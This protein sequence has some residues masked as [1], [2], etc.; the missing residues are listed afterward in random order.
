MTS[1]A[2]NHIILI[3][4]FCL[5][6]L[7]ALT[8]PQVAAAT[9]VTLVPYGSSDI[10]YMTYSLDHASVSAEFPGI[11]QP[12]FD[13]SGWPVGT[14]PFGGG[15]LFWDFRGGF[16]GA[17]A[18]T[19]WGS[20]DLTIV[21]RIYIDLPPGYDNVTISMI[22]ASAAYLMV[23]GRGWGSSEGCFECPRACGGSM[24]PYSSWFHAGRNLVVVMGQSHD[25]NWVHYLDVQVTADIP[26]IDVRDDSWGAI[27]SLF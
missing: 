1:R 3:H 11:F 8:G 9:T 2:L 23:N 26:T 18:A 27:K 5:S 14:E 15:G 6:G 22:H 13:D 24:T 12:E 16:C 25:V 19:S 17:D 20:P 10:R 7:I 21:T 4:I